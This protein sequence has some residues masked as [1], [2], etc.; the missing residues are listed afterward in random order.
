M[1]LA[2]AMGGGNSEVSDTTTKLYLECAEF[3]P[4]L[5]RKSAHT[6]CKKTDAAARFEKGIDSA[7]LPYAI[8]RLKDLV[9]KVAG[10]KVTGSTKAIHPKHPRL[11]VKKQISFT[12]EY[13]RQFLGVTSTDDEIKKT[14]TSLEIKIDSSKPL[15]VAEPPTYRN[16]L[17]IKEDIA[18]E[19]A[20]TIGFDHIPA[21]I[22]PLSS[23]PSGVQGRLIEKAKD[24]LAA[25]GLNETL[26]YAFTS[27]AWLKQFGFESGIS[28]K[29]PLSEEQEVMVPS[30][31]PGLMRQLV[32]N[33]NRTFGSD[34]L[35]VR[36]FEIRPVF[37]QIPGSEIRA[38]SE[39][40]TGTKESWKMSLVMSGPRFASSMKL[41]QENV[42]FSDLKSV[43]EAWTLGLGTKGLRIKAWTPERNLGHYQSIFHPG[44]TAEL[45]AGKDCVGLFGKIHPGLSTRLKLRNEQVWLA[46]I[47]W[48]LVQKLS[49]QPLQGAAFQAWNPFPTMERDFALV[50]KA[51]LESERIT[52]I[53]LKAGKPL[54]KVAKIFDVY[55]GKPIEEGM[56]SVAV[57]VIFSDPTRSLTEAEVE[58]TSLAIREGWKKELGIELRS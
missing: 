7:N 52:G 36:L 57:R 53:A 49:R 20:R 2:G 16:D 23:E 42:D 58:K 21:T 51:D 24:I 46:E 18:E 35:A 3:H 22:P 14:L 15:W 55:R 26:S 40:D 34:P 54:A 48:D 30:L 32:E 5:V 19:I 39:T 41:H 29:N 43:I 9:I 45:W 28:I 4:I 37:T 1:A 12:P 33:E 44:Q 6:H 13:I 31:I 47:D 56:A 38:T 27:R 11:S 8:S 10:G 50:V 25:Q 17:S